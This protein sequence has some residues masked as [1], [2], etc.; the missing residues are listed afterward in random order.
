MNYLKTISLTIISL[1][2]GITVLSIL[3]YYDIIKEN[4]FNILRILLIMIIFIINGYKIEKIS[5]KKRVNILFSITIAIIFLLINIIFSNI[6]LKLLIYII[7]IIL[8]NFLGSFIY[9]KRKK[10]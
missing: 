3:F 6:S 9:R 4:I 2:I 8:S 10:T 1:L 5:T 7:I